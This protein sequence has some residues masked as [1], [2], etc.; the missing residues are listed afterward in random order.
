MTQSSSRWPPGKNTWYLVKKS[1]IAAQPN[2][3]TSLALYRSC[4]K[5][6]QKTW[7][8]GVLYNFT[9]YTVHAGVSLITNTYSNLMITLTCRIK[10][11]P[12]TRRYISQCGSN[13]LKQYDIILKPEFR[14]CY[15]LC[16]TLIA[17]ILET[18]ESRHTNNS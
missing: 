12:S 16:E 13:N 18:R 11:N 7:K 1:V 4:W 8:A 2:Q 3:L 15:V 10:W 17:I 5:M 6:A 9:K 14:L